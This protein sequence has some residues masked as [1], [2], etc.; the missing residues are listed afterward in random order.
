MSLG[1]V[2]HHVSVFHI[3]GVNAKKVPHI[4]NSCLAFIHSHFDSK[5]KLFIR[6]QVCNIFTLEQLKSAR[7]ILYTTFS[8]SDKK[9][10]YRGPRKNSSERDKL[11]DAFEGIFTKISKLDADNNT[12]VF[13]VPSN[14]LQS[15]MMMKDPQD[16]SNTC[17]CEEKFKKVDKDMDELRDTFKSFVSIVTSNNLPP[18]PKVHKLQSK[19]AQKS[20]PPALRNR[21]L[22][23]QSKRSASELSVDDSCDEPPS[24]DD[25]CVFPKKS[26]KKA[27]ITSKEKS[28]IPGKNQHN[29]SDAEGNKKDEKPLYSK[30]AQRKPLPPAVKGTVKSGASLRGAVSDIFIFNCDAKCTKEDVLDHFNQFEI[31]IR[32]IEKKSHEMSYRSSFRISPETKSDFDKILSEGGQCLPDDVCARKFIHRRGRINTERKEHFQRNPIEN[33]PHQSSKDLSAATAKLLEE[34]DNISGESSS[35][36]TENMDTSRADETQQQHNGGE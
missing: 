30:I 7:E 9:Y 8:E 12:P 17:K 14:E 25:V 1:T 13:S 36:V 33:T 10:D 11:Y 21:L 34:L 26:T 22:S 2:G 24:D 35:R 4:V 15:M 20:L 6:E 16:R 19:G 3:D 32:N 18:A 29:Q 23:T 5:D 31:K 27:R 28:Q